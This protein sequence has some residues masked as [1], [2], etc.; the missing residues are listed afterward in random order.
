MTLNEI[1]QEINNNDIVLF[2]KGAYKISPPQAIL[3][4]YQERAN[5]T[6]WASV[7]APN[8]YSI[9]I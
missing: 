8:L 5:A 4:D 2:I 3:E 9:V 7:T 1:K 6:K